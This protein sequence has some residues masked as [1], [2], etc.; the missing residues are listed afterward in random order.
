M[1]TRGCC[2]ETC[3]ANVRKVHGLPA[4]RYMAMRTDW[5]EIFHLSHIYSRG[6]T[7][8]GVAVAVLDTGI[9]EHEDFRIAGI[10]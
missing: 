3:P 4:G 10:L 7:G 8:K 1:Q 2:D 5:E 9:Y 6:I